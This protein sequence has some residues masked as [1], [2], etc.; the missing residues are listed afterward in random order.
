MRVPRL[1][2][3]LVLVGVALLPGAPRLAAH[4][5]P[6]ELT[7]VCEESRASVDSRSVA[8]RS[9]GVHLTIDNRTGSDVTVVAR[10][11]IKGS[12]RVTAPA[13]VTHGTI[14]VTPGEVT[15]ACLR[16]GAVHYA[17]TRVENPNNVFLG[18]YPECTGDYYMQAQGA[19][20]ATRPKWA[21]SFG[22][23]RAAAKSAL[24][25]WIRA[26]DLVTRR[27]YPASNGARFFLVRG[28]RVRA[29]VDVSRWRNRWYSGSPQ[30]C[31]ELF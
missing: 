2:M 20:P 12:D 27:G 24:A 9:D 15:L 14:L 16:I 3:W 8:T 30:V 18:L 17:T 19:L 22:T 4:V 13:G 5:V 10:N 31:Q 1:A 11:R 29:I 7:L 28:G 21:P 23:R 26:G 25:P 6:D